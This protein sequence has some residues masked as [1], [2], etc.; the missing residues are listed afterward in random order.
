MVEGESF[1]A[2]LSMH[3]A[4]GAT[5]YEAKESFRAVA[6]ALSRWQEFAATLGIENT[7]DTVFVERFEHAKSEL[8]KLA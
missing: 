5:L 7:D 2:L 1:D 4:F 6:H 8:M 3:T